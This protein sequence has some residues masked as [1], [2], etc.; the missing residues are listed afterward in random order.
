VIRCDC[1]FEATGDGDEELV[2]R[3]QSHALEV[4]GMEMAAEFVL[5]LAKAKV[6]PP[7]K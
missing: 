1:G 5:G 7:E 2:S 6:Q 3:A 4:H